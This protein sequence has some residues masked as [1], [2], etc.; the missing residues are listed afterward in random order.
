MAEQ[1][2]ETLVK[3]VSSYY[4]GA[5]AED[6]KADIM[7]IEERVETADPAYRE[8]LERRATEL[9]Q[10][11]LKE[12]YATIE[13]GGPAPYTL[14][15][16]EKTQAAIY[17]EVMAHPG[18]A[19]GQ[20]A[21]AKIQEA[22]VVYQR[23]ATP[24]SE[25]IREIELDRP[26]DPVWVPPKSS[27]EVRELAVTELLDLGYSIADIKTPY[28]ELGTIT[29][30][31]IQEMLDE[32]KKE[33][34]DI[35]WDVTEILKTAIV[36]GSGMRLAR[37]ALLEPE[38]LLH[39][40]PLVTPDMLGQL[41]TGYVAYTRGPLED[42]THSFVYG[43]LAYKLAT[44]TI[45]GGGEFKIGLG[46]IQVP[47]NSQAAG[48]LMLG[49]IGLAGPIIDLSPW[50]T[51]IKEKYRGAAASSGVD[52]IPLKSINALRGGAR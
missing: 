15:E 38:R 48:L 11:T 43:L 44:T 17:T 52:H 36:V 21:A 41:A 13:E 5:K 23:D 35:T 2:R 32:Q 31:A 20:A 14:Y 3:E 46:G 37:M 49:S 51:D 30:P 39:L 4:S 19:E 47:V 50:M 26:R 40:A 8:Y 6:L 9:T 33:H 18:I 12:Q 25:R 16:R 24:L 1:Y 7:T 27:R 10:Q 29:P 28:G 45:G 22:N 42:P 34:V